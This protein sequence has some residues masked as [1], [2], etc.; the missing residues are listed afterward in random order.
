[1]TQVCRMVDTVE[2]WIDRMIIGGRNQRA[3]MAH[4]GI[5]DWLSRCRLDPFPGMMA[6]VPA[7]G[8][9]ESADLQRLRDLGPAVQENLLRLR[10]GFGRSLGQ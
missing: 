2:D 6:Q 8:G 1:M 4:E 7:D 10:A 5:R 9:P 3:W